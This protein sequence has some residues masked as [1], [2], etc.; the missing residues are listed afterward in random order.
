MLSAAEARFAVQGAVADCRADGRTRLQQR[1]IDIRRGVS[2]FAAGSATAAIAATGS[3]STSVT[4]SVSCDVT[5]S[6]EGAIALSIDYAA[7]D[8]RN[9]TAV[10]RYL[11]RSALEH[12][13]H[14]AYG[15]PT[16][17]RHDVAE[18]M[19]TLGGA[20]ETCGT[21]TR[22]PTVDLKQLAIADGY[23]WALQIDVQVTSASAGNVEGVAAV[24]VR[25]ALRDTSLPLATVTVGSDGTAAVQVDAKRTSKT[26]DAAG[27]PFIVCVAVCPGHG[28]YVVDPD[29]TE[30]FAMPVAGVLA[31]TVDGRFDEPRIV[32]SN[33][34]GRHDTTY[35]TR[36]EGD[37]EER[38]RPDNS[39]GLRVADA[40]AIYTEVAGGIAADLGS[41]IVEG[42][43]SNE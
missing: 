27:A 20:P 37:D 24:A 10:L 19:I 25:E 30:H 43:E 11:Q 39:I 33:F 2:R 3:G 14:V 16:A 17:P 31:V 32:A 34:V 23:S 13:L 5:E 40:V 22:V 6:S 38:H 41:I 12:Q 21:T 15:V 4:A 18:T 36:D 1:P 26:F 9:S 7:D 28:I 29:L 35:D 42:A 8:G